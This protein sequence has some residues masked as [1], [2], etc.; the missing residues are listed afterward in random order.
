MQPSST[1]CHRRLPAPRGPVRFRVPG[2]L[3]RAFP[4]AFLGAVL[5]AGPWACL[6][7]TGCGGEGH[8][9]DPADVSYDP[10]KDP[11]ISHLLEPR[12]KEEYYGVQTGDVI[13]ILIETLVTGQRDPLKR[14]KEDLAEA[15]GE[16]IRALEG[17]ADRFWHDEQGVNYIRNVL[18][19][20]HLSDSEKARPLLVRALHHPSGALRAKAVEALA[21]HGDPRDF[22]SI[23]ATLSKDYTTHWI[24]VVR[25]LHAVDR[26]RA[27]ELFTGW[28]ETPGQ[29]ELVSITAPFLATVEDPDLL[30]R[31]RR[32]PDHVQP[33]NRAYPLAAL[34]REGDQDALGQLR[35]WQE[36]TNQTLRSITLHALLEAGLHGELRRT[37]SREPVG[38]LR[39]QAVDGLRGVEDLG[40]WI[41]LLQSLISDGED[42]VRR[43]ALELLMVAGDGEARDRLF[44]ML[45]S[46]R[47]DEQQFAISVLRSLWGDR[48]GLAE[49]ALRVLRRRLEAVASHPP[50]ESVVLLQSIGQIPLAEATGLLIDFGLDQRGT[51]I[52]GK[53]GKA[54][55][56]LQAGNGGPR[57]QAEIARRLDLCEDPADRMD[58]LDALSVGA[59]ETARELLIER[60]EAGAFGPYE[61]LFAAR[62]LVQL[63]PAFR[64][65]PVLKRATLRVTQPDVR[66]SL[67]GLLWTWYPA[68]IER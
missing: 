62:R 1:R 41:P 46:D 3:L 66:R 22:D 37:L 36:A 24:H 2:S 34:A 6:G 44:G 14:A 19:A 45:D 35:E 4:P 33:V 54:W 8:T 61:T 55:I 40:P 42:Q 51:T 17:L 23:L 38:G 30:D 26:P 49:E 68:P 21:K 60:L 50:R 27:E 53:D 15:G 48:P 58:F 39:A 32:L 57:A 29:E 12:P 63:G 7:L 10:A 43:T 31:F 25:A 59:G 52:Q 13:P 67:Q 5:W 20:A 11:R 56:F 9:E 47:V 28:L 18:D 64:V 65:L 16:G